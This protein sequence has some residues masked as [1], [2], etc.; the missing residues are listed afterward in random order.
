MIFLSSLQL[1]GGILNNGIELEDL[2]SDL[3]AQSCG[4]LRRQDF[5]M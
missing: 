1:T 2:F 3:S 4:N 5:V